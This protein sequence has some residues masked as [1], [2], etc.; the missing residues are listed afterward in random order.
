L[1]GPYLR[2]LYDKIVTRDI[3]LRYNLKYPRDLKEIALYAISQFGSRIS[4]HKLKNIFE[5]KSIHTAK[6]YLHYLE[7]A[8]LL[9]QL[10]A[11]TSKL[12][13][14]MK[15]P[16]KI[17]CI[18]TGLI[19]SVVPRVTFDYGKIMENMAYLELKRRRKEIYFYHQPNFEI[20]FLIKEGLKVIQLIQVSYSLESEDTRKREIRAL[21]KGSQEV[22]CDNLYIITW[23]TE[24]QESAKGKTIHLIPLWK[25][26]LT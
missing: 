11:F 21:I 13:E 8:Y 16:R 5:I 22:N 7:E 26:L 3:I 15:Q 23:D 19:N 25:W 1:K 17:Y 14:Q 24:G 6:N 2:E 18:D 12:K 9:F 10:N 20:D 4:Y